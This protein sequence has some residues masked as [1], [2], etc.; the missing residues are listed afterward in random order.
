MKAKLKKEQTN[1]STRTQNEVRTDR[2]RSIIFKST[3]LSVHQVAWDYIN[4]P[5]F[6][7]N[8][9]TACAQLHVSHTLSSALDSESFKNYFCLFVY[10]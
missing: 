5:D 4:T 10:C 1:R 2:G 9:N 8:I 7:R 6:P 3:T